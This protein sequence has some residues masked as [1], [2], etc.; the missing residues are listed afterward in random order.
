M[1]SLPGFA[2]L[3]AALFISTAAGAATLNEADQP[4]GAFGSAWDKLT[5]VGK[6]YDIIAGTGS[7]NQFDNFVFDLPAGPQS[8]T[9]D[10]TAPK[11]YDYSLSAG[12]QIL[13]STTPFRWGWDGTY[14]GTMQVDYWK[15]SQSFTLDLGNFK[16]GSL[17]L[18]LNFTHGSG[19][20]Y[21]ISVPGNAAL[22][23]PVTPP[24]PVPVPAGLVLLATGLA[25][26]GAVAA[27]RRSAAP[28]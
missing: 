5:A 16:G 19:L 18:A 24:A 13:T 2:L 26:L 3:A 17:Y 21:N 27:R 28:A 1:R 7:Q 4:G 8:L 9:F 6:G 25:A 15:P 12:G 11:G 23:G 20:A 22:P 14:A 10:F